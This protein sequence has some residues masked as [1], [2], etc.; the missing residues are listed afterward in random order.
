MKNVKYFSYKKVILKTED[1]KLDFVMPKWKCSYESGRKYKTA[2]EKE[3][4]WIQKNSKAEEAYCKVCQKSLAPRKAALTQH[5][6]TKEHRQKTSAKANSAK[7][8]TIFVPSISESVR[9]TEL[10]LAACI[11]CHT[12]MLVIDHIGEIIK[13]NET[14]SNIGK[15]NLH[16]T[17]CSR[18]INSVIAPCL[19]SDLKHSL[20]EKNIHFSWMNQQIARLPNIYV[21]VFAILMR[22]K[23]MLTQLF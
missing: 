23:W 7:L 14:G 15:I 19:K 22:K 6:Q 12:S 3:F 9:K 5:A 13:R 10:E 18:L 11:C 20:Q 2:W 1:S 16:R 21:F 4:P 17:K 8:S